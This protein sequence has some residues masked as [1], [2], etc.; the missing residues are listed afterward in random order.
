M[1]SKQWLALNLGNSRL[2][3][4]IFVG[5]ELQSHWDVTYD[6]LPELGDFSQI[7]LASVNPERIT[8]WHGLPST[9]ILTLDDVPLPNKYGTMGIDRALGAWGAWQRYGVAALVIDCGTALTLTRIDKKGRFAGGAILP[10]LELLCRCL[11]DRVP[12]LPQITLP[13]YPIPLWAE[14]TA[15]AIM[16][17]VFYFVREGLTK[18]IQEQ[19]GLTLFT[20]GDGLY[21]HRIFPDSVFDPHLIFWGMA[22]LSDKC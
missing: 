18:F 12:H 7:L 4:G 9:K 14:A 10:G 20:G 19:E 17:G 16:S 13:E 11:P 8:P 5:K 22:E 15:E 6:K 1:L 21:W 3:G 2:H